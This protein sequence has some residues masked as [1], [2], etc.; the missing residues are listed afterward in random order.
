MMVLIYYDI[1][2]ACYVAHNQGFKLLEPN[3]AVKIILNDPALHCSSRNHFNPLSGN[4]NLL[5]GPDMFLHSHLHPE[6]NAQM[7]Q[8]FKVELHGPVC[9]ALIP[10]C[11]EFRYK[12]IMNVLHDVLDL[13]LM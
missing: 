4:M 10:T 8:K 12:F 2:S 11:R 9:K 6:I 3:G 7:L 1:E 5:N 13:N